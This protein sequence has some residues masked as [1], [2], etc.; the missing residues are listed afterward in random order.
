MIGNVAYDTAKIPN[1]TDGIEGAVIAYH[2]I[3]LRSRR[4][5]V[6]PKLLHPRVLLK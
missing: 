1:G 3:W 4:K 6:A 5:H 2:S